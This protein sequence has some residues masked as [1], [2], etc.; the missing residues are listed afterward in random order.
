VLAV[1][2]NGWRGTSTDKL[3]VEEFLDLEYK[4]TEDASPASAFLNWK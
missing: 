3:I 4:D 2:D 1:R